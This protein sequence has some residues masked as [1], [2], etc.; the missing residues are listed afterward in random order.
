M[1]FVQKLCVTT[2]RPQPGLMADK[3]MEMREAGVSLISTE[4]EAPPP[5]RP[6]QF[7]RVCRPCLAELLG[8]MLRVYWLHV[9]HRERGGHGEVVAGT[10]AP[11]GC[12]RH[13]GAYGGDKVRLIPEDIL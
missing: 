7:E 1:L 3:K 8:T 4:V 6:N 2:T 12:G 10:G 11:S 13:G 9:V 5:A